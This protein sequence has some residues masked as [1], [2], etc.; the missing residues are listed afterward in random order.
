MAHLK[1]TADGKL[2]K[3]PSGRLSKDCACC[4]DPCCDFHTVR[5]TGGCVGCDFADGSPLG[6]WWDTGDIA[7]LCAGAGDYNFSTTNGG[8]GSIT[9]GISINAGLMTAWMNLEYDCD[10]G[11]V[12]YY[13]GDLGDCGCKSG[14]FSLDFVSADGTPV[15]EDPLTLELF[16]ECCTNCAVCI[17][18]TFSGGGVGTCPECELPDPVTVMIPYPDYPICRGILLEGESASHLFGFLRGIG[19]QPDPHQMYL[20]ASFPMPGCGETGTATY[21]LAV[22]DC[23]AEGTYELEPYGESADTGACSGTLTCVIE[24]FACCSDEADGTEPSYYLSCDIDYEEFD[25]PDGLMSDCYGADISVNGSQVCDTTATLTDEEMATQIG[26]SKC[27]YDSVNTF[28]CHFPLTSLIN[29]L[30]D[31]L[32]NWAIN[33][34]SDPSAFTTAFHGTTPVGTYPDITLCY[35]DGYLAFNLSI[36]NIAVTA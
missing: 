7:T 20:Y 8:A 26:N 18:L 23:P 36:T 30:G 17:A 16:S 22:S 6:Y 15:C 13:E 34:G 21:R 12:H 29:M 14:S 31:G 28:P 10:P 5:I 9:G 25:D 2:M 11:N 27:G 24:Y 1:K 35:N 4:G 33:F 19:D 32:G 3:S